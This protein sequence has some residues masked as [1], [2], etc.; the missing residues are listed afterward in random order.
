MNYYHKK[1]NAEVIVYSTVELMI[2]KYCP[3]NLLVNKDKSCTVCMNGN[4]YYLKD[5]NDEK[6]R[7]LHDPSHHITHIMHHKPLVK[8]DHI[9]YYKS[10]G[11]KDYRIEFL[12]EKIDKCEDILNQVE[13]VLNK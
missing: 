3:L 4:K 12:D 9:D 10:L 13:S 6:Y 8:I 1:V 2:T 7:L 5:R 11:I